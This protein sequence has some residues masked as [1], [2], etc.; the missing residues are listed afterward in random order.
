MNHGQELSSIDFASMIGGPLNAVVEA[1]AKSAMTT[2]DFIQTIGFEELTDPGPPPTKKYGKAKT[3]T[4]TYDKANPNFDANVTGSK[5]VLTYKLDVPTLAI[6]PIPYLR[7]EDVNIQFNAKISSTTYQRNTSA[8]AY[9]GNFSA[10]AGWGWGSARLSAYYSK[11]KS[12][13][14]GNQVNRT[15]SLDVKVH[16][17]QD[18]IP[19]GL[20]RVLGIL[21]DSMTE[22]EV[23]PTPA[24]P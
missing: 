9:G 13:V 19:A 1:Q 20:D 17:V 12:T 23:P 5:E 24:N 22:K 3:V 18:E 8:E 11:R 14:S 15:Y 2:L 21:E 7:V 6:I 16:A 10:K 4:F